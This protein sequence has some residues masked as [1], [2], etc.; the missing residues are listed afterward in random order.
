MVETSQKLRVFLSWSGARSEAA[1]QSFRDWLPSVLQNVAPYYTPDD[2]GKGS[3]WANEIRS[4]LEQSDFGIIFLTQENLQSPWILFEAG[5][6]SKFERSRVAPLLIGLEPTDVSGP[7]SQLQLTKFNR[8]EILKLIRGI[9]EAMGALSLNSAVLSS[10]FDKW[11][12][13]LES[14]VDHAMNLRVTSNATRERTDREMLT[15]VLERVRS[16][17]S[18][19][20]G[21]SR[22]SVNVGHTGSVPFRVVF[23]G[24]LNSLE[25]EDINILSISV[26][27]AN[28]LRAEGVTRIG[29]LLMMSF[30]DLLKLPNMGRKAALE[31]QSALGEVQLLLSRANTPQK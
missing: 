23:G 18:V 1:A 11:W 26:R 3:R 24:E 7:L 6:L 21:D 27:A 19:A 4:E 13:D 29:Q 16:I 8:L 20:V 17:E 22:E 30:F 9:N 31:V 12:P 2:I 10:V 5:A 15:E 14:G 25:G 28:V